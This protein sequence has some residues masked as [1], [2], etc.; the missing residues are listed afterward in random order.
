MH[1]AVV[2]RDAEELIGAAELALALRDGVWRELWSGVVA[3]EGRAHDPRT[4]A[5]AA[6]LRTGPHSVLSGTTAAAMHGCTAAADHVV[7]VTVPYDREL[8][9]MPGLAVHNAWIRERDIVE[10]DGLRCQALDVALCELLCTG[11][12]RTALACLEQALQDLAGH[13]EQ[14]R[15]LVSRR[16]DERR[17]RRGTRRGADLLALAWSAPLG[18]E[19]A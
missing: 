6:L 17:D 8:R 12:K 4:V 10:L 5:A 2:R 13:G 19:A 1:G 11:P 3:P 18:A 15:A 9:S 16:L 14:F 7:H